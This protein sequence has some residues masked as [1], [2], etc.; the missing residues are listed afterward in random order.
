MASEHRKK[1]SK[2]LEELKRATEEALIQR[3]A[4]L[5]AEK[6][7]DKA[8]LDA[9]AQERSYREEVVSEAK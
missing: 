1:K 9:G 3:R 6:A 8:L 2:D 5:E 7:A 4:A